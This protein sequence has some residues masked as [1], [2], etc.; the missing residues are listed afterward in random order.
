MLKKIIDKIPLREIFLYG[1]IGIT[2]ASLDTG[3][4]FALTRGLNLNEFISNFLGIN[5]GIGLSF[6]LNSF[7]NF[8]KTDNLRLRALYFFCVGYLGLI[9]SMI[10]LYVGI[11]IFLFNDL[12]V[13]IFSVFLVA[14][15]QYILNKFLT[16][17]VRS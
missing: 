8:K 2:A 14:A 3:T 9:F 17:R 6:Y 10:I 7:Y 15:I 1:V 5:L 13:K 11:K 12:Y 4:Y 16:F